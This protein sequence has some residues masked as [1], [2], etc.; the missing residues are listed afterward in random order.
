MYS[1]LHRYHAGNFADVH[2]HLALIAI[3]KYLQQK[4]SPF[5]VLDAYA[6]EGKYDLSCSESQKNLEYKQGFWPLLHQQHSPELVN[7]YLS[8]IK[9]LHEQQKNT[10][11]GS[12]YLIQ[13]F[14]R[15]TDRAILVEGHPQVFTRLQQNLKSKNVHLHHR[16]A[17]EAL[18]ALLPFKEKRGLVFIDP[19]Y[20]VKQEYR[21]LTE[22]LIK[23]YQ[24]FSHGIYLLW[25]PLLKEK[26]HQL[27][28][29]QLSYLPCK[30]IWNC[31]WQPYPSTLHGLL[32]SGIIMINPPWQID[33]ILIENFTWLNQQVYPQGRF[34]SRWLR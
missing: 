13:H 24:H 5:C 30:S 17:I 31:E 22:K 1:Y 18:T 32:G 10:F 3:L 14:L 16:D 4:S 26:F 23:I 9:A 21:Q 33:K 29:S 11:P 20:E 7:T 19:S 34:T 2:K 15:A 27:L 8:I 28:I 25:Y 6:G 12:P